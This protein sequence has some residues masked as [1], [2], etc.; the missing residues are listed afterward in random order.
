MQDRTENKSECKVYVFK[1][2]IEIYIKELSKF[3]HIYY[4]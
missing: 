2:S 1:L 4:T 3:K